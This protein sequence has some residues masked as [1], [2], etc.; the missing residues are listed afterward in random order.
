MR[1]RP[2]SFF[3]A[4]QRHMAFQVKQ[5]AE[6]T[7]KL[8]I[9]TEAVRKQLLFQL[10]ALF[11]MATK[12]AVDTSLRDWKQKEA[13]TRNATYIAQTINKISETYDVNQI[14]KD[15]ADLAQMLS[16]VQKETVTV[17]DETFEPQVNLQAQ[18][19]NQEKVKAIIERNQTQEGIN[20]PQ[21]SGQ[22]NPQPPTA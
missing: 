14:D 17:G 10:Q 19:E 3:Q 6:D 22:G 2:Q 15:L 16:N 11:D 9:N 1:R 13:W 12:A 7:K 20:A 4:Q 8:T 21:A 5:L 18:K